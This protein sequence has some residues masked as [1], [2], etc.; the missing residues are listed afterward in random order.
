METDLFPSN[1]PANDVYELVKWPEVQELM[2]Y[3]W[4]TKECFPCTSFEGQEQLSS[5]Y[6]VPIRRLMEIDES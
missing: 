5:A 4:F 6:F 1:S 2:D 3:D